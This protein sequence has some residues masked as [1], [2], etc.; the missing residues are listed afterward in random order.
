MMLRKFGYKNDK[1]NAKP[2]VNSVAPHHEKNYTIDL[3]EIESSSDPGDRD[4]NSSPEEKRPIFE[5]YLECLE[6]IEP[7]KIVASPD[8][9]PGELWTVRYTP[10]H[11]EWKYWDIVRCTRLVIRR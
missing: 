5:S 8:V 4:P 10:R 9:L 3:T 6:E 7:Q 2:C 11:D 1:A